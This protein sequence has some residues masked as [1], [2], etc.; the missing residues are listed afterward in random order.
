MKKTITTEEIYSNLM[1]VVKAQHLEDD[2]FL[3][4]IFSFSEPSTLNESF[5]KYLK[6][7]RIINS[8]QELEYKIL[9]KEDKVNDYSLSSIVGIISAAFPWDEEPSGTLNMEQT[10]AVLAGFLSENEDIYKD[11]MESIKEEFEGDGMN[12]EYLITLAPK[13]TLPTIDKQEISYEISS[14]NYDI[15]M[16]GIETISSVVEDSLEA[17][18]LDI[19]EKILNSMKNALNA[20]SEN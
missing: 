6:T 5:H 1:F 9:E 2:D 3:L 11:I 20:E 16:D 4:D 15:L 12:F 10:Y 14:K 13:L 8:Q 18:E 19:V 17:D 7:N